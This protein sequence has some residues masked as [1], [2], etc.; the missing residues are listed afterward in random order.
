[1]Q[2]G[3]SSVFQGYQVILHHWQLPNTEWL[4]PW[5]ELSWSFRL[6][7]IHTHRPSANFLLVP[8]DNIC[9][10]FSHLFLRPRDETLRIGETKPYW[11][12]H[13]FLNKEA[14][15]SVIDCPRILLLHDNPS[16]R[17][18]LVSGTTGPVWRLLPNL[19]PKSTFLTLGEPL[20][21]SSSLQCSYRL[22]FFIPLLL[23]RPS[24]FSIMVGVQVPFVFFSLSS[25]SSFFS[26]L[27]PLTPSCGSVSC[28]YV[29]VGPNYS[30][31][32]ASLSLSMP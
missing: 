30:S 12:V 5:H 4:I 6:F 31:M 1:M 8:E 18:L 22:V 25:S 14:T 11:R 21:L 26:P 20:D 2:T 7:G 15:D 10:F 24:S 32:A 3:C 17:G 29:R 23:I 9:F 16:Y 19:V 13:Q 27:V 28:F